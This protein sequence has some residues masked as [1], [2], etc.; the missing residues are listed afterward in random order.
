MRYMI[1]QIPLDVPVTGTQVAKYVTLTLI[2]LFLLEEI[3]LYMKN[4]LT[5]R[6]GLE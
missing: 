2:I 6:L 4:S 3:I 5:R 1:K